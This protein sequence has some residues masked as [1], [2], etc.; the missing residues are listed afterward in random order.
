MAGLLAFGALISSAPALRALEPAHA[1]TNDPRG[2]SASSTPIASADERAHEL[3]QRVNELFERGEYA[4]ALPLMEQVYALTQAPRWL[5]NLG[6]IHHALGDCVRALGYY[7]R[8]L[9][10]EPPAQGRAEARAALDS[11]SPI[12]GAVVRESEP[13]PVPSEPPA[14]LVSAPIVAREAPMR[15]SP[16]GAGDGVSTRALLGW[17]LLGVGAASGV[18][19]LVSVLVANDAASDLNALGREAIVRSAQ[20]ETY[21]S[22]CAAR[23]DSLEAT[24]H[25]YVTL[26]PILGLGS[27]VLLGAGATLLVL[28]SGEQHTLALGGAGP[29]SLKY[30]RQF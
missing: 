15:A 24:R 22:C 9:R 29:L 23:G 27:L 25:R 20:G 10:S 19:A 8:Y 26:A 6:V 21:D 4:A 28:E 16:P 13:A 17:S 14:R 18:T 2:A 11:L 3:E 12:C 7:E 1:T 30:A 5:F